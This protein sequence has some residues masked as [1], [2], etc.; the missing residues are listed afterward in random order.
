M[1]DDFKV[2][3]TNRKARHDYHILDRFE[4]GM[5][6]RGTE[7]KSLRAGKANLNDAYATIEH[8]EVFLQN[9]S[10]APYEQGNRWNLPERRPH[11]LLLHQSEIRRLVGAVTR[12]GF[13][14][15]PLKMFFNKNGIAKIEIALA[16]GKKDIDR[17]EDIKERDIARETRR[18]YKFK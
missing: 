8:G 18:E 5:V 9:A 13:T 10:I 2:I 16:R 11:K 14:I 1:A 17:R 3:A 15:V 12:K 7:V 6:L 4:A